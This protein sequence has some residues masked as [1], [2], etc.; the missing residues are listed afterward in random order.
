[1]R[2]SLSDEGLEL[3]A[4]DP[5]RG[6]AT[7]TMPVNYEGQQVKAGFNFRYLKDVLSAIDGDAVSIEIIDTLSP[8]LIR[9]PDR[10]EMLFVVMPMRL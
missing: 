8:T 6:E 9:D 4:S 1:V 5:D 3:Y 2:L 7:E 10:E